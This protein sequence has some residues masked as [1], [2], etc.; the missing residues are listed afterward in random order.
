MILFLV[1]IVG[2]TVRA[3]Q[4]RIGSATVDITPDQP[5]ALA[6]RFRTRISKKP[7]TPMVAAAGALRDTMQ[8]PR[9]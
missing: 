1:L 7:Q 9:K 6:G 2:A 3:S 4:F 8:A 5:V